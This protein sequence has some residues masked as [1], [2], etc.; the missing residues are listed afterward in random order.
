VQN[1]NRSM[2]EICK[3]SFL[4]HRKMIL[5]YLIIIIHVATVPYYC[6]DA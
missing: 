2:L 6:A 5:F 3:P 4:K 1:K